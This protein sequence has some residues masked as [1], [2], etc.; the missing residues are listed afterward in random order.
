MEI[1]FSPLVL[2]GANEIAL[3]ILLILVSVFSIIIDTVC[4]TFFSD[5][6]KGFLPEFSLYPPLD[7]IHLA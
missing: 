6:S 3:L 4:H 1:N 7:R 5:L 2:P